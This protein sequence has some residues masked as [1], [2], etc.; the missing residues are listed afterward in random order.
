MKW[1]QICRVISGAPHGSILGQMLFVIFINDI[2]SSVV[3]FLLK[4]ADDM[5]TLMQVPEVEYAFT[6]Q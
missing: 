5:K 3:S 2:D 4:F 6:L 1:S